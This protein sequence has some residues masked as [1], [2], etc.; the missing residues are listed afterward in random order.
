MRYSSGDNYPWNDPTG[1]KTIRS[2][3]K[4]L[5]GGLSALWLVAMPLHAAD[6]SSDAET[7]TLQEV[8]ITG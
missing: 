4:S 7:G 3:S 8:V 1:P 2:L 6:T 5:I